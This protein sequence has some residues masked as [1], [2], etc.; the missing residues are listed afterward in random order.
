MK[1]WGQNSGSKPIARDL[2]SLLGSLL[3]VN[4][5]LTPV[6]FNKNCVCASGVSTAVNGGLPHTAFFC[7]LI[8]MNPIL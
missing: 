5:D 4:V 7:C 8:L 2:I 1:R 3:S 6:N